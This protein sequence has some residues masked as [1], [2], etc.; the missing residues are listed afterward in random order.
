VQGD[1]DDEL[2]GVVPVRQVLVKRRGFLL[3]NRMNFR[4]NLLNLL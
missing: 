3:R 1:N 2:V 4:L